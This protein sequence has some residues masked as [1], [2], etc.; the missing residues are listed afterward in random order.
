MARLEFNLHTAQQRPIRP[1]HSKLARQPI[2][3]TMIEHGEGQ[4]PSEVF[5]PW[6]YLT[7]QVKDKN[8]EDFVVI[9]KGRVVSAVDASNALVPSGIVFP[10]SSGDIDLFVSK[11]TSNVVTGKIDTDFFGYNQS[12]AGLLVPANGGIL[13]SGQY[14]SRDTTA[15][16]LKPVTGEVVAADELTLAY[17]IAANLPV[18]YVFHDIYQDIRGKFLNFQHFDKN[19][20]CDDWYIEVPYLKI[21]GARASGNDPSHPD[22]IGVLHKFDSLNQEMAYLTFSS[23]DNYATGKP[24]RSDIRGNYLLQDT[25]AVDTATALNSQTVGKIIVLDNR[26][27]KD[28]LEIVDTYPDSV[29]P[30]TET[31]GLPSHLYNFVHA[32]KVANSDAHTIT[33]VV[34]SVQDGTFGVAR[35][36][37]HIA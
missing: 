10:V 34:D 23:N 15:K 29:M 30:G 33:D 3:N 17:T 21:T 26:F 27:P 12:V 35:M 11:T 2:R 9:P 32:F 20:I 37:I 14:T 7:A 13:S 22:T 28:H 19:G 31:G 36:Q 16:T 4:R 1:E 8:L 18:G 6:K 24:V 25:D 5:Y